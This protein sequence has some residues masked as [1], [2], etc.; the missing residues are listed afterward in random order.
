MLKETTKNL[1]KGLNCLSCK[2]HHYSDWPDGESYCHFE[3]RRK[4]IDKVFIC[5]NYS[6]KKQ[7]DISKDMDD[8]LTRN[9]REAIKAQKWRSVTNDRE[10]KWKI[11]KWGKNIDYYENS[12]SDKDKDLSY[13]AYLESF[14]EK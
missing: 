1:L 4:S 5:D 11:D 14:L 6:E 12:L 7:L 10:D 3:K 9:I 2:F 8:V 13:Q